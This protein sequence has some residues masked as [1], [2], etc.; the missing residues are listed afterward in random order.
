MDSKTDIK[1]TKEQNKKPKKRLAT[2]DPNTFTNYFKKFEID[3]TYEL[4][5]DRKFKV[6]YM[7]SEEAKKLLS[8]IT[9]T[10]ITHVAEL[11]K[12]ISESEGRITLLDRDIFPAIS[13]FLDK[14]DK[15]NQEN[16]LEEMDECLK[17]FVFL[18]TEKKEKRNQKKKEKQD[19]KKVKN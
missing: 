18:D 19:E 10:V 1:K 8:Q 3:S 16:I 12:K 15:E 11:S 13:I 6:D 4:D 2:T 17:K 5:D 9:H 7:L 14:Y